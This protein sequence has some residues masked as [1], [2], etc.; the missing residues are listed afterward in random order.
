MLA[1]ICV[2]GYFTLW[3]TSLQE[4]VPQHA[5]S[6]VAS[7][8][9]LTS[10]GMIPV[11]NIVLGTVSAAV[12]LHRTLVVMTVLGVTAAAVVAA[13]PSVRKLPRGTADQ[14]PATV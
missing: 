11:G 14:E 3:E 1:G 12:G 5:L 10:A 4:H 2:T 6:R 8:D 9:Y 7:Y 13:V